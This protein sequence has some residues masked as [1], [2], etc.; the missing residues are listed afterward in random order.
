MINCG[1][2]ADP[3]MCS[4]LKGDSVPMPTFWAKEGGRKVAIEKIM[5]SECFF[6][7]I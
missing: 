5:N 2:L 6:I 3:L 4:L 1:T 7:M